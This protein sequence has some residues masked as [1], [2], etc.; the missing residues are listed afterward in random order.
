MDLLEIVKEFWAGASFWPKIEFLGSRS[1][2]L[3]WAA[4]PPKVVGV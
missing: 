3:F 4:E 2:G 1:R